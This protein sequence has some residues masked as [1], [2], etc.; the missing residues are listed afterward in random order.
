[1]SKN[2]FASFAAAS[3]SRFFASFRG[4][5]TTAKLRRRSVS[6]V[7][8]IVF[9]G[10]ALAAFS[11]DSP[12]P[13]FNDLNVD[14]TAL[15]LFAEEKDAASQ[16]RLRIAVAP[17]EIYLGESTTFLVRVDGFDDVAAPDIS[18]LQQHFD[19]EPLGA[20][21][22]SNSRTTYE[23]GIRRQV[24]EKGVLF[25]YRLTPRKTGRLTFNA[26]EVTDDAGNVLTADP[27]TLLVLPPTETNLV[28]LETSVV[29]PERV[30]PLTPFE[31][32]VDVF[33]KELPNEYREDEP[34]SLIVN[35]IGIPR[36]TVPWLDSQKIAD[37]TVA[38]VSLENW[39]EDM[40][41]D[42]GFAL[43]DFSLANAFDFGFS[44]FTDSRRLAT[45]LPTPQ[46]VERRDADGKTATYWKYSFKRRLRASSAGKLVFDAATLK[47]DFLTF[48]EEGNPC[49]LNVYLVSDSHEIDVAPIPEENAPADYVGVVGKIVPTA[50]I[51]ATT[52][53]VGDA[54][55][56]TVSLR[57][58]GLFDAAQA[59]DLPSVKTLADA[60][61]IYSARERSLDDG[62]AFEYALRPLAAG[63]STIP[64]ISV[65]YFDVEK[66]DFATLATE[67]LEIDVR[68]S[69]AS[70]I[71]DDGVDQ[72]SERQDSQ[73]F[74][75]G[76]FL[77]VPRSI[78]KLGAA[79]FAVL[80]AA[81]ATFY[82]IVACV[83]FNARR[84]ALGNRRIV[85]SARQTLENGLRFVESDP[86]ASV[87]TARLA[88]LQL[89]AR[90]LGRP[91]D[92]STD[93]EALAFL[94]REFGTPQ[95]PDDAQTLAL[96]RSFFRYAERVR[97]AGSTK[98]G[99]A[100]APET[101]KLFERWVEFLSARIRKLA[102]WAN[103]SGDE[104]ESSAV[105][106]DAGR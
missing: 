8:R 39:L 24:D 42:L 11:V 31:I 18:S 16:G 26:P 82:G 98:L 68:P 99:P 15:C 101:R 104:R 7:R 64:A 10:V 75:N 43:N 88:F 29:A 67:P 52:A 78:L 44:L 58:H 5:E 79:T 63:R 94:D 59:P 36:L 41:A 62:I 72:T 74:N 1:M 73:Y 60:F 21:R 77:G 14:T 49:K 12:V 57:G 81:F 23:N 22:L 48:D 54:L 2:L 86:T 45:F 50:E 84:V 32:T 105:D 93:A 34:I 71:Q 69:D 55:T 38:G 6:A 70:S 95:A 66:G 17:E 27:A 103:V 83:R 25:R 20:T 47:G 61:K 46:K 102:T 76:S 33:V 90:R 13:F 91:V 28:A 35:N 92:S 30:F 97:F 87:A 85:E 3:I 80:A 37:A 89:V 106:A 100:F 53:A 51:S 65:S 19:L 40:R 9:G 96:L 4:L 56:L